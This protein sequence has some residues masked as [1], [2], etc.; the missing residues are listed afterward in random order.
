MEKGHIH[1]EKQLYR[2]TYVRSIDTITERERESVRAR[3]R[4]K[5]NVKRNYV[6]NY[7]LPSTL[8]LLMK[9]A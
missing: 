4:E 7:K 2:R 1:R 8:T 5:K 6:N 9:N 3:A